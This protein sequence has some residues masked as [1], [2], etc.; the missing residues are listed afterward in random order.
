M[1]YNDAKKIFKPKLFPFGARYQN[2]SFIIKKV[3]VE[4][5]SPARVVHHDIVENYVKQENHDPVWLSLGRKFIDN[6]FVVFFDN[7]FQI[8]DGNHRTQAARDR[9]SERILAIMP[10]SHSDYYFKNLGG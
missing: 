5:I 2:E 10:K 8:K 7:K 9:G 1:T 4:D 3:K 6:R